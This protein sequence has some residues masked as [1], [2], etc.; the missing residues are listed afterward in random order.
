M[1][2]SRDGTNPAQ[3]R[4]LLSLSFPFVEVTDTQ[5]TES[6]GL[7][8]PL[9]DDES[10]IIPNPQEEEQAC[11]SAYFWQPATPALS[12]S[13]TPAGSAHNSM[14]STPLMTPAL[15]TMPLADELKVQD[16]FSEHEHYSIKEKIMAWGV[17]HLHVSFQL[18]NDS[19]PCLLTSTQALEAFVH[20]SDEPT[21]HPA[22]P[23][24]LDDAQVEPASVG[25]QVRF[26]I[27]PMPPKHEVVHSHPLSPLL[28]AVT[29][30]L[31]GYGD[32]EDLLAD[33]EYEFAEA[34]FGLE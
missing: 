23:T 31:F 29:G 30:G 32:S 27:R 18:A 25:G 4:Y 7:E 16:Y 2:S 22:P 20:P 15:A 34:E 13:N 33:E 1:A 5:N 10:Y 28:A 24:I 8:P 14:P 19:R 3:R 21:C 6:Y 9:D 12:K 26:L 11:D 17:N